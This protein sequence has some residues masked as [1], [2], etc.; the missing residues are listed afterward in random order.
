MRT[1][2]QRR[3]NPVAKFRLRLRYRPNDAKRMATTW[4]MSGIEHSHVPQ[5]SFTLA[6]RRLAGS[7]YLLAQFLRNK[8][9]LVPELHGS[10]V[11]NPGQSWTGGFTPIGSQDGFPHNQY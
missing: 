10:A 5:Y 2:P 8:V 1:L 3:L 7:R 4:H 9:I 11:W 6:A